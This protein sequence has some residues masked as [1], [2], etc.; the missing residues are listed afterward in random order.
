M[1]CFCLVGW[2]KKVLEDLDKKGFG[3]KLRVE[4]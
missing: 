4:V 2:W 1:I 3:V